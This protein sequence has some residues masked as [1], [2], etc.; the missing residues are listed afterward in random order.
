MSLTRKF[1]LTLLVALLM[2]GCGGGGST[3]TNGSPN[4][5]TPTATVPAVPTGVVATLQAASVINIGWTAVT[6]ATGYNVYR[7]TTSP[8]AISATSK[9]TATPVADTAF[10]DSG[11]TAGTQY[12]YKVTAVNAAGE[13]AGST[14]VTATTSAAGTPTPTPTVTGFS[15]S[16]GAVGTVVT[17]TGT[18]LVLGFPPAPTVKF[19][20]VNAGT[21]YTNVSNAGVTF[22]VPAGLAAGTYTL[23]IGGMS[24]TPLTVGTFTVT[25]AVVPAAPAAPTGVVATAF[26]AKQI[27]LSWT[28]VTGA[29]GYNIYQST[30]PGVVV[31]AANK[32]GTK[33]IT[34]FSSTPLY[35][36][37]PYYYVVTARNAVGES[38]GSAE[39]SATTRA[40]PVG[41]TAPTGAGSPDQVGNFQIVGSVMNP[42][43][44]GQIGIYVGVFTGTDGINVYRSSTPNVMITPTNLVNLRPIGITS[45]YGS[46]W[47]GYTDS[48]LAP[49]TKYYYRTTEVN[50]AGEGP[51]STELIARTPLASVGAG[52]GLTLSPAFKGVAAIPNRIPYELTQGRVFTSAYEDAVSREFR[53]S[54]MVDAVNG[55]R[56][57]LTLTDTVGGVDSAN[58]DVAVVGPSCAV[59]TAVG[60]PTCASLGITLDRVA[61]SI[62][63]SSTPMKSVSGTTLG[64]VF[65]LSGT[66]NFTPF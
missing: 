1:M 46:T 25:A 14:E 5:G 40:I 63:F 30:S 18:N 17:I 52:A 9:V 28:A 58:L 21:P 65:N 7:A 39:V 24:G 31:S 51:G 54:Y 32:V 56:L 11:L 6:G 47:S 15:P 29:T 33:T 44:A 34:Y 62:G 13:S 27:D 22:T 55:D 36:A 16:S 12:F 50:A 49:G 4:T 2:A 35:G 53:F 37:T 8:V 60:Y 41:V 61:G 48:G 20:T 45:M 42:P 23:T 59:T 3:P 64:S 10:G 26:S 57:A 66:L 38:I 43:L 19:G